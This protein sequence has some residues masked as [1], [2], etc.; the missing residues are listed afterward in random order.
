MSF[1]FAGF[2]SGIGSILSGLG[3]SLST[4][5]QAGLVQGVLNLVNPNA[6]KEKA[7]LAQMAS[8][9]HTEP[10]LLP[11]LAR[12]FSEIADPALAG[13]I[14]PLMTTPPTADPIQIILEV[15][16]LLQQGA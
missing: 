7:L 11:D 13:A 10:S 15:E 16:Q 9:A 6:S 14:S 3:A 8:F 4:A 12:Q 1:S 2:G 5:Q